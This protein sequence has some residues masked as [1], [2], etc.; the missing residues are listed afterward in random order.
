VEY[1]DFNLAKEEYLN[2]EEDSFLDVDHLNGKGAGT[3]TTLLAELDGKLDSGEEYIDEYFK[4][5]YDEK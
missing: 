2:L 5:W 3:V 1:L 4:P